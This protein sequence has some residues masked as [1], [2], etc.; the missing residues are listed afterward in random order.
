MKASARIREK[1]SGQYGPDLY[2]RTD[3]MF[4]AILAYLDEEAERRAEWEASV[5]EALHRLAQE[6]SGG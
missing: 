6:R 1:A 4:Q 2:S 3:A 5:S